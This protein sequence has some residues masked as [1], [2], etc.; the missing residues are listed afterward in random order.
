[1]RINQF[2]AHQIGISRRESDKF[3][4][5]QHVKINN[6]FALPWDRVSNT[7]I[8]IYKRENKW[9]KLSQKKVIRTILFYKP[10]F[11]LCSKTA[12]KNKKTI[13]DILPKQYQNLK[14][15]G[16]LDYM[17]EGLLV[18]STDGDLIYKLTHPKNA[19]Q[20]V[21]IVGVGKK[22][23]EDFIEKAST[24]ITIEK[25]KLN[26]VKIK[27]LKDIDFKKYKYLNLDSKTSWYFF[28]LSEG[29][30]NQIR[31]MVS[32]QNQNVRRLIRV[33]QDSFSLTEKIKS[34]KFVEI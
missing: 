22:L 7:D 29:R 8:V 3:I 27:S 30:N 24:G 12:E 32:T 11:S 23:Q 5:N 28:I 19:T 18:L 25:Y 2:L 20:K 14:P 10:I 26:S 9:I 17:S 33:S 6:N 31:K 15:A 21:Y 13:Y 16:R 4:K 34:S 1:M